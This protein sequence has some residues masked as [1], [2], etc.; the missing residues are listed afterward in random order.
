MAV[1]IS[2]AGPL[3]ALAK[4]KQLELLPALFSSVLITQAILFGLCSSL[5]RVMGIMLKIGSSGKRI[6]RWM[7]FLQKWI[8]LNS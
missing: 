8:I 5:L 7:I 6:I 4:I 3:I 2:D 1:V